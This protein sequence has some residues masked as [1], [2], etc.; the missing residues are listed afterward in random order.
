METKSFGYLCCSGTILL[1]MNNAK[2]KI[3][4][5]NPA[6][7][8][9][10]ALA[11]HFEDHDYEVNVLIGTTQFHLGTPVITEG[12]A[13][14]MPNEVT[15]YEIGSPIQ[16]ECDKI[17]LW[18]VTSGMANVPLETIRT[19]G[20]AIRAFDSGKG[21]LNEFLGKSERQYTHF[22]I[23]YNSTKSVTISTL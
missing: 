4:R 12:E 13:F 2:F 18:G 3:E 11:L 16:R 7:A 9:K 14:E 8:G 10:L 5:R 1:Q 23:V 19:A 20:S 6:Q 21:G 22:A 17:V 15:G